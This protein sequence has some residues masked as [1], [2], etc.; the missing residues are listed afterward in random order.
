M[1]KGVFA[2][3]AVIEISEEDLKK[4]DKVSEADGVSPAELGGKAVSAYLKERDVL[5]KKHEWKG[6]DAAFGLW[7]DRGEDALDYQRR[8]RGE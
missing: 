5:V 4:L 6:L 7:K 3:Q 2:M 1:E 8:I